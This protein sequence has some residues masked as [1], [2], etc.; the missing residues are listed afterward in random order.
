MKNRTKVVRSGL[1]AGT[2]ALFL[3]LWGAIYKHDATAA[4]DATNTETV[5]ASIDAAPVSPASTT[6][7]SITTATKQAQSAPQTAAR[8]NTRTRA[9]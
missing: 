4:A 3:G 6:S 9:S 8:V 1:I 2:L 7:T 5:A